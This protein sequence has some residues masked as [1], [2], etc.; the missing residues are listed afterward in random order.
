MTVGARPAEV[1]LQKHFESFPSRFQIILR[2]QGTKIRIGSH[3]VIE[4]RGELV[5]CL[6][7][8]NLVVRAGGR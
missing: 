1:L 6:V 3:T 4:L 5:E 7:A 8:T 2:V